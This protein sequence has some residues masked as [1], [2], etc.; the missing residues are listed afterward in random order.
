[1]IAV[2]V[3]H[4][5]RI[6]ILIATV[7]ALASACK[8]KSASENVEPSRQVVQAPVVASSP[9]LAP[10]SGLPRPAVPVAPPTQVEPSV[11][12]FAGTDYDPGFLLEQLGRAEPVSFKPVGSTSTVFHMRLR[13]AVGAAFKATTA[14]RPRGPASEVAAYR[15]SR[16]LQL[17]DVPPAVSREL[18][19]KQ[20]HALLDPK[21]QA[22]WPEIRERMRVSEDGVVHGAAIYWIPVLA[23]V[24]V[25]K[26]AGLRRLHEWL[27]T[28]GALPD[29]QR[30]LAASL[31]SLVAFDYL[32]GNFDRW[33]GD[34][35]MGD[36]RATFV[37]A[38][39]HDQAFPLGMGES[40]RQGLL[41]D[42]LRVERFS[43][44]F[45]ASLRR[46]TRVC[47]EQELARDPEGARGR[48]L[49]ERQIADLLDR[50]QTLLSHIDALIALHGEHEVLAFE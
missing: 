18:A 23:D 27:R 8:A 7:G 20:I 5:L 34:N 16:C 50:R 10:A 9:P 48:L 36:A 19:A 25:D 3:R 41:R 12:R 35:V 15:L 45:H 31:S 38:R 28:G 2:T 11:Q 26:Q 32:I 17:D 4:A 24:G 30:S 1:M 14:N 22:R 13:G 6:P 43:R 21:Y 40:L 46:F 47:L 39:D 33:S 37:Y 49:S 29:A 44:R 42:L